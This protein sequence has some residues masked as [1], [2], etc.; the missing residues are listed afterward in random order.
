[1]KI[2]D[3][4][5]GNFEVGPVL[6]E[7]ILSAPVQ[8]LKNIHQGGAIFLVNPALNQTRYAHSVGVLYLV[9]HFGGGIEEQIAALLHDVSHTAFSHVADY[10]F[11]NIKEDYHE[12]IFD[13][14]INRSEIPA[15]LKKYR[16]DSTTLFKHAHTILE[17]PLPGLCADRVD[18]TLRDLYQAG[19][20]GLTDIRNFISELT[21]QDGCMVVKSEKAG[22][23]IKNQF[24]RLN[25][26]YFKKPEHVYA[27]LKLAELIKDALTEGLL[28]KNDLLRD[29]FQVLRKL[30]MDKGMSQRLNDIENLVHFKQ[31]ANKGATERFKQRSL[32]PLVM[33]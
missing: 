32:Y 27:N 23:W 9:K 8:R 25:E 33:V 21:I 13:E 29:D 2:E 14:V 26:A 6:E 31:F 17:Q 11:E 15:I 10:V 16:F 18:Y 12:T 24:R 5:Y 4:I 30:N 7:L 19:F 20:I 3:K 28:Q 22:D 1:M